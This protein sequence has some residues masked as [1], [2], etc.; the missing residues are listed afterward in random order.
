ML[1]NQA[2]MM[3]DD[4]D[5]ETA[6]APDLSIIIVSWNT[7]DMTLEAIGSAIEETRETDYELIVVDNAS[8]DGSAEAI[9]ETFPDLDHYL[10]ETDNHGFAKANNIAAKHARGAYLLLLNPD[11]VTLDGAIDKL[12]AFAKAYPEAGIWGG[13]TVFADKT[14]LNPTSIWKHITLWSL[15]AHAFGLA[16]LLNRIPGKGA[17]TY[18]PDQ[19]EMVMPVDM[20]S[21]CFFLIRRDLWDELGGFDLDYVMYAEEA[22]LCRRAAALGYQ[23][24]FT[25]DAVI[26]HYV[27]AATSMRVERLMKVMKARVTLVKQYFGPIKQRLALMLMLM[28]P[29]TRGLGYAILG[30]LLGRETWRENGAGWLELFRRRSE[31]IAGF[32]RS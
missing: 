22:D 14:T 31:W 25:P 26:V 17:E 6:S 5:I 1:Q 3:Q 18:T 23:P 24:M 12:V 21:G 28:A 19:Y 10:A 16:P 8:S 29:L 11:T 27:G 32:P 9:A 15:F 13:K 30:R 2:V 4:T 7:K 20:V